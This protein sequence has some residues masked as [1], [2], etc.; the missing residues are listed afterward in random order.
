[1]AMNGRV[2][3]IYASLTRLKNDLTLLELLKNDI[4]SLVHSVCDPE[5]YKC[6]KKRISRSLLHVRKE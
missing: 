6:K 4:C 2:E 5:V 3:Y 1:M